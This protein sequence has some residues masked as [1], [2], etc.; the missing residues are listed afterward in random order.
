M[1]ITVAICTYNGAEDVPEVLDHLHDQEGVDPIQWE[2]L[3]IDNN[4]TDSTASV[5]RQYQEN[6]ER[7]APLRYAFE[8]RQG[9]SHAMERAVEEARGRWIAFLDDDNLPA[10]DWVAAAHRFAQAHPQAGAFGGQIHGQF[11]TDPP[12]SF[13]VVEGLFAIKERPEKVCYS[14]DG[15]MTFA[16]PGAGLVVR[17]EAW[18]KSVPEKGLSQKGTVE[19]EGG[20]FAEDMELQWYLYKNGW[21]VWHNPNMHMDH[22]IPAERFEKEYLKGFFKAHGFGRHRM[23]MIRLKSWQRPLATVAYWGAD[24]WKLMRMAWTYRGQLFTDRFVRGRVRMTLYM[25]AAPFTSHR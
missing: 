14:A 10:P 8:G 2:V 17:R 16:A 7:E 18:E 15:S 23:R 25:L 12:S 5:V 9:K 3:V 24:L 22:K 21:E 11:E 13:G 4:S 1:D 19:G 20:E 6:W